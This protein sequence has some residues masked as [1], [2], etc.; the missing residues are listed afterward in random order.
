M[1]PGKLFRFSKE[2]KR[3]MA[4][5]PTPQARNAYKRAMIQAQLHAEA[6]VQ[7]RRNKEQSKEDG[8]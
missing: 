4:T 8:S 7:H 1:K 3:V 2:Y 5:M 6:P